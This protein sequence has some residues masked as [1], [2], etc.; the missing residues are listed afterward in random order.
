MRVMSLSAWR[1]FALILFLAFGV[2]CAKPPND[3]QITSDI[4]RKLQ[5]DSGLQDKQ[6]SV[7]SSKGTVTLAGTVDS[8]AERD[9]AAKYAAAEPGVK[10]VINNLQIAQ[11]QSAPPVA[12]QPVAPTQPKPKASHPKHHKKAEPKEQPT[13]MADAPP[14]PPPPPAQPASPA[15]PP[16]AQAPSAP[17]PPP[18]PVKVTIPSGVT[19]PI[20]LIN[21]ID[22]ATAQSG[23]TFR[24]TLDSPVAVDGNVVIPAHYDVVGHVVNAQS[25]GKFAGQALLVLQLDRIQVGDKYYDIQTDQFSQKTASRGK[26][27]GE[28]VGAGAIAGAILGGIFGGGKGAAIGSAAGAGAGGGVQAASKTPEIQL[29]SEKLLTFTLQAPVTVIPTTKPARE[30]QKLPSPGAS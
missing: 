30:G 13:Q 26:N 23:D 24:A 19:I 4:E 8:E 11:A 21:S 22:S 12:A 3:Q 27:T 9:A 2:G 5:A 16:V 1:S 18:E 6:L 14:P 29:S 17:P 28:K 15:P 10:T 25:S 7:D 20:R